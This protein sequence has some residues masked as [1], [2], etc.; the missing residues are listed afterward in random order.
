MTQSFLLGG[1]TKRNN[2]GIRSAA[3]DTAQQRFTE[4]SI[5]ASLGNPTWITTSTDGT[6]AFSI[7]KNEK[8]G[9]RVFRFNE[10]TRCYDYLTATYA[11]IHTGC[12]I[13]YYD[14]FQMLYVA[15]YH[16]GS[17]DRY[18]FD[19]NNGILSLIEQIKTQ[20][21]VPQKS[22]AHVHMTLLSPDKTHLYVC[23][24]G[25]DC[26]FSFIIE[27]DGS[28]TL[29]HQLSTPHGSGPRHMVIHPTLNTAYVICELNNTT[30]HLTLTDTHQ[31]NLVESYSNITEP[32]EEDI[33]PAG[34]AI[35]LSQ[36][37][38]YLYTSTR[39]TNHLTVFK[40]EH[41][42]ALHCIQTISTHG[43]IPRD[44]VLDATQSFVMVAH[45][46]SDYITLFNRDCHTGLLTFIKSDLFAPECVCLCSY[47]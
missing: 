33:T 28:L 6:Y 11:T 36:D 34:A 1:Y 46:E 31:F 8:G 27:N 37:G 19:S 3:F 47:K 24:L 10:Q 45:Q 40:I 39:F 30:L 20:P 7:D 22:G 38:Q 35:R 25:L 14:E 21:F 44:F 29:H 12:H 26:I 18:F 4:S 42:G 23:D 5:I 9:I 16:E 2:L 17:I 15:N 41:D 32:L 13:T 43:E